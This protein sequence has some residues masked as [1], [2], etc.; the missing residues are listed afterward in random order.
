MSDDIGRFGLIV[1]LG[2]FEYFP[3]SEEAADLIAD[4]L[5][6]DGALVISSPNPER[7]ERRMLRWKGRVMN[8]LWRVQRLVAAMAPR[9][10]HREG[11]V[12][13]GVQRHNVAPDGFDGLWRDRG[14]RRVAYAANGLGCGVELMSKAP[15]V[16]AP[17][18]RWVAG[19]LSRL[20]VNGPRSV[21]NACSGYLGVYTSVYTRR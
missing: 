16:G 18:S 6:G 13:S 15:V 17:L 14:L 4:M 8:R 2:V 21:V 5:E 3:R 7:L 19:G 1:G 9:V 11:A 20:S 10:C 12:A